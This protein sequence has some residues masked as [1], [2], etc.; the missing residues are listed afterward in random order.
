MTYN[1]RVQALDMSNLSEED[2]RWL[3]QL[4]NLA[5]VLQG[6]LY[7]KHNTKEEQYHE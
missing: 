5:A 1:E 6:R 7:L 4:K 3:H 2:I